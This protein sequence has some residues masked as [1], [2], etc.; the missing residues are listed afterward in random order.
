M[1]SHETTLNVF[2]ITSQP[3]CWIP[4]IKLHGFLLA[5]LAMALVLTSEGR[6]QEIRFHVWLLGQKAP[7]QGFG[8]WMGFVCY[9]HSRFWGW[10]VLSVDFSCF[11]LSFGNSS[12]CLKEQE[13]TIVI[14]QCN[15]SW[16][17]SVCYSLVLIVQ[18]F[19]GDFILACTIHSRVGL[20]D[21]WGSLLKIPSCEYPSCSKIDK[22]REG[23]RSVSSEI[24]ITP[25]QN[26]LAHF[27]GHAWHFHVG[28]KIPTDL[29]SS[30]IL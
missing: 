17:S 29:F 27:F 3:L 21:P 8:L 15:F 12:S 1:C 30:F 22:K 6:L 7:L 13:P 26:S 4:L 16:I 10:T 28:V 19:K 18:S 25:I 11:Q 9:S 20:E 14:H 24:G 23:E 2:F 5:E